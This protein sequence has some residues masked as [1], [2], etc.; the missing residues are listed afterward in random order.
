ALLQGQELVAKIDE[1]GVAA[2]AAQLEFEQAA[3]EGQC[4]LDVSNLERDVIDTHRAR[5]LCV[6][7]ENLHIRPAPPSC[8]RRTPLAAA[9]GARS[10]VG[11]SNGEETGLLLL[12][13]ARTQADSKVNAPNVHSMICAARRRHPRL[14]AHRLRSWPARRRRSP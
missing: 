12:A 5:L 2:L 3:V 4:L 11:A 6:R 9:V 8:F 7:H 13:C 14:S 1:G 10:W